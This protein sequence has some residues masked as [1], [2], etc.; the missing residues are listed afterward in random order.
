M[1]AKRPLEIG[2]RASSCGKGLPAADERH[3]FRSP[4]GALP[5]L[6]G[7]CRS[8]GAG[9]LVDWELCH[10]MGRADF[11][12]VVS[13]LRKELIRDN[14]WGLELPPPVLRK[15]RKRTR[16]QLEASTGLTLQRAL[17]VNHP[18]VGIQT[19]WAYAD[20]ATI[21]HCAQHATGTCC[22]ACVDKWLGIPAHSPLSDAQLTL[23]SQFAMYYIDT[24]LDEPIGRLAEVA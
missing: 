6:G 9:G 7:E 10:Q 21:V 19:T 13:E 18:R 23:L 4:T 17:M 12:A 11:V 14:Y 24:R 3:S 16:R 15:A 2:C 22:R 8:C 5:G 20:T 1:S